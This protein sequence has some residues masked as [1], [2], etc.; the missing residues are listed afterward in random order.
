MVKV[1][2]AFRIYNWWLTVE[3]LLDLVGRRWGGCYIGGKGSTWWWSAKLWWR[4]LFNG[5]ADGVECCFP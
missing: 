5:A 1:P 2:R 4:G 3:N